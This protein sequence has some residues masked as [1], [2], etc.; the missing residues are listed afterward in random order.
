MRAENVSAVV[1]KKEM[2]F[3]GHNSIGEVAS[4][5]LPLLRA[6]S[7]PVTNKEHIKFPILTSDKVMSKKAVSL[8]NEFF[9]RN[10]CHSRAWLVSCYILGSAAVR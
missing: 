2:V 1:R 3:I 4:F 8:T 5:A 9:L 10:Y 6:S 7:K